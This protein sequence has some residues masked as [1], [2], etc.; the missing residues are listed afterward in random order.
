MGRSIKDVVGNIVQIS[1]ITSKEFT[2]HKGKNAGKKFTIYSLGIKIGNDWF[3]IKANSEDKINEIMLCPQTKSLYEVGNEV[4]IYLEAEDDEEKY[5]KITSIKLN[6]PMGCNIASNPAMKEEFIDDI[7]TE[8]NEDDEEELEPENICSQK[9]TGTVTNKFTPAPKLAPAVPAKTAEEKA[10]DQEERTAATLKFKE[11]DSDKYELGMAKNIAAELIKGEH[12][13]N[14]EDMLK[15]YRELVIK[16]FN[17]NKQI[18][19]EILGI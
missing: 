15:R 2:A 9:I 8:W 5:W 13:E 6:S 7:E 3:N 12:Y 11:D 14:D 16:T 4:K 19:K 17:C 10:K 1:N 18:R